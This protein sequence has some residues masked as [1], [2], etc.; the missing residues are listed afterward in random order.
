MN[1]IRLALLI[2][3][4]L[5]LTGVAWAAAT[6]GVGLSADFSDPI[7]VRDDSPGGSRVYVGG[8]L[9]GGK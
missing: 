3:V 1:A 8:G 9:H 6:Q 2:A 4:L 7:S 5:A